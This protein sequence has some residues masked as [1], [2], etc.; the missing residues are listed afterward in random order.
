MFCQ[1]T[2]I[3]SLLADRL[4]S[5]LTVLALAI[6]MC[7]TTEME[8]SDCQ[9]MRRMVEVKRLEIWF[10]GAGRSRHYKCTTKCI[11]PQF[12]IDFNGCQMF[13]MILVI[14]F[15]RYSQGKIISQVLPF[16]TFF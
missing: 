14:Q 2:V 4:H 12:C 1:L 10:W 15:L 5:I 13:P 6:D 3:W 8:W 11:G 16:K 7:P 9:C